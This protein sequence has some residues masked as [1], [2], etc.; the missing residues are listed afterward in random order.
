MKLY[1]RVNCLNLDEDSIEVISINLFKEI[2]NNEYNPDQNININNN[3][4]IQSNDES[5]YITKNNFLGFLSKHKHNPMTFNLLTKEKAKA[6]FK[7]NSNIR[8]QYKS[9]NLC[10]RFLIL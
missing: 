10:E 2:M 8:E 9:K 6:S 4:E 1:N 7:I 5:K 3:I